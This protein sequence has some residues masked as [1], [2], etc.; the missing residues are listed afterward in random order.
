MSHMTF[1]VAL[2]L[3]V[4]WSGLTWNMDIRHAFARVLGVAFVGLAI[5]GWVVTKRTE[6]NLWVFQ[7]NNPL[8]NVVHWAVGLMALWASVYGK[9]DERYLEPHGTT[10]NYPWSELTESA[11]AAPIDNGK[12]S[13][14]RLLLRIKKCVA[15]RGVEPLVRSIERLDSTTRGG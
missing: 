8:D 7:L 11:N 5:A 13:Q 2:G 4:T 14:N 9:T 10:F 6:P 12:R 1:Y 15:A 3:L